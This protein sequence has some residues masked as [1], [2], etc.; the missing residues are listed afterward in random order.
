MLRR[1]HGDRRGGLRHRPRR[2]A[3]RG[4]ARGDR[5]AEACAG[6]A[7]LTF[8]VRPPGGGD[9]GS[10]PPRRPAGRP[11]GSSPIP[12]GLRSALGRGDGRLNAA[13]ARRVGGRI[14]D[15]STGR[16]SGVVVDRNRRV[17]RGE[18]DRRYARLEV[19]RR[20]GGE[21][22]RRAVRPVEL[23]LEGRDDAAGVGA[24]ISEVDD[25]LR[26]RDARGQQSV[27]VLAV[28]DLEIV[29]H[30][31]DVIG[32]NVEVGGQRAEEG[33]CPAQALARAIGLAHPH[34]AG[35]GV[36]DRGV[37]L[38]L[39]VIGDRGRSRLGRHKAK[40]R[41]GVPQ[42]LFHRDSFPASCWDDSGS[43]CFAHVFSND[44]FP[45]ADRLQRPLDVVASGRAA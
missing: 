25:H 30:M 27:G 29:D 8:A 17:D 22:E 31:T 3:A 26:I 14:A 37:G 28:A 39:D 4:R 34:R 20:R 1:P 12:T 21:K 6:D 13:G 24:D 41:N 19:V 7:P 35:R 45:W 5:Q 32:L 36:G 10:E 16:A 33:D 15:G 38:A 11:A 42:Q 18:I 2:R 23:E 40:G 44:V 43:Q 9:A